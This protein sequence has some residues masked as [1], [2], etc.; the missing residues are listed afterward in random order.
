LIQFSYVRG[1]YLKNKITDDC[2]MNAN[3]RGNVMVKGMS[4]EAFIKKVVMPQSMDTKEGKITLNVD[5]IDAIVAKK[6][7]PLDAFQDEKKILSDALTGLRERVTKLEAA[8][9]PQGPPP[10]D[11]KLDI[12]ALSASVDKLEKKLADMKPRRGVDQSTL[13]HAMTEVDRN[14]NSKI[15]E[16]SAALRQLRKELEE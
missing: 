5:D 12:D 14:M 4:I 2:I 15:E 7:Q 1:F 16:V 13:D 8:V 3:L 11:L 9:T 10:V 6:M